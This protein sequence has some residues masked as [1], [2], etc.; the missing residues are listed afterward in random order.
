MDSISTNGKPYRELMIIVGIL[1]VG[2][3]GTL[4]APGL[5][6][7]ITQGL[8]LS[9][10]GALFYKGALHLA[11]DRD[12]VALIMGLGYL[13]SAMSGLLWFLSAGSASTAIPRGFTVHL[14]LT[15][16]F[17]LCP[18][19]LRYR[20]RSSLILAG[21]SLLLFLT[22]GLPVL[23]GLRL[24]FS[25]GVATGFL[26]GILL[27]SMLL[28]HGIRKRIDQSLFTSLLG[29]GI[30]SILSV[31]ALAAGAGQSFLLELIGQLLGLL[32]VSLI[33]LSATRGEC[34][35]SSGNRN[36]E[37]GLDAYRQMFELGTA[38][39]LLIDPEEA[40]TIVKANRAAAEFYGYSAQELEQM[41]LSELDI[42]PEKSAN[43]LSSP[44]IDRKPE[45]IHTKHRT[46]AAEVR[47]VEIHV[48][49]IGVGPKR[50][51]FAI[52]IDETN[53]LLAEARLRE[54]EEMYRRIADNVTDVVWIT[55]LSFRPTYVSPSVERVFGIPPQE[56]LERPITMTYPQSSLEKFSSILTEQ[57]SREEDPESDSN[58]VFELEVERYQRDGSLGWDAIKAKFIRDAEGVPIAILG[59]SRDV[60]E[61]KATEE[62]LRQSEER[63]KALHNASFGGITIHDKGVIIE[64]NQGLSDIT[65][66]D[67]D[68]LIGMDGL[69][70]IAPEYR[71]LVR[72]RI[73]SGYEKAYEAYGR[74]KDGEIYPIRLEARNIPYRGRQVRVVEF[75]DITEQKRAEEE[76]R[77]LQDKLLQSQK[78]DAVGRLA[79][80]VA[81][82]F[83]NMLGVIIGYADLILARLETNDPIYPEMQEILGAAQRSAGLTQ[84]LLAFSRKQAIIPTSLDVNIIV[85]QTLNMLT[86]LIGEDINLIWE[87]CPMTCVVHIDASQLNQIL[88][89][90]CINARD[91]IVTNGAIHIATKIV[92][93]YEIPETDANHLQSEEYVLLTVRDDGCGMDKDTMDKMFEPFFTQKGEHGTGLGLSTVYGIVTQNSGFIHVSSQ[94]DAGTAIS[95]YLPHLVDTV[96]DKKTD[97]VEHPVPA[98]E[99]TILLVDDEEVVRDMVRSMLSQLDY[100]VLVARSPQEAIDLANTHKKEIS[101]LITDVVMPGMNGKELSEELGR[102]H[103]QIQTLFMSGYTSNVIEA[104]G[105][106]GDTNHFIQ[107]PFSI[108]EIRTKIESILGQ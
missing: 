101:L 28:L 104:Q 34:T 51:L 19:L 68:E 105:G 35:G 38:I 26:V 32:S 9:S 24:T 71:E 31:V 29:A 49:P 55:D 25:P 62:A 88:V 65:G 108:K 37:E 67:T 93:A 16:A 45:V 20:I 95:I 76:N 74:R 43:L 1:S 14:P 70:L 79:G 39:G 40:G 81:H 48:G 84:Q 86:K 87:P 60:S 22:L 82:D 92:P 99:Y 10:A 5:S 66:Y 8:L 98:S 78:M 18:I 106:I 64:C 11:H 61:Q 44:L 15:V 85:S 30:A 107:K 59:T 102:V 36:Q 58:R 3:V 77:N 89:N 50:Y 27:V 75:R 42:H 83:N 21:Y 53:K 41:T 6:Y 96:I 17:F 72:D 54:S 69:L 2:L 73:R 7:P 46:R 4:A 33:L 91:A 23:T 56:F 103:D 100:R 63:F 12:Q 90:L 80:G 97:L 52:V 94:I 13:V 47:D 57:F